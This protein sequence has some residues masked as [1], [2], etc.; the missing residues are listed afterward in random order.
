MDDANVIYRTALSSTSRHPLR[1]KPLSLPTRTLL[2]VLSSR[3]KSAAHALNSSD[4]EASLVAVLLV[5]VAVWADRAPAETSR[6]AVEVD[7]PEAVEVLP[8]RRERDVH[9]L[10]IPSPFLLHLS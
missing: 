4:A 5:V 1:T 6:H 7:L 9:G 3:L 10:R 8:R 2:T